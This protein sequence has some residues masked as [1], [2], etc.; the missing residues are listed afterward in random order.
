[1]ILDFLLF[2]IRIYAEEQQQKFRDL[3]KRVNADRD[4]FL[5]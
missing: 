1:M 2:M 3:Q 5:R 4:S